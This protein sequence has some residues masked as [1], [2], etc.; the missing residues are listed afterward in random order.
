MYSVCACVHANIPSLT[1]LTSDASLAALQSRVCATIGVTR[2][3]GDH[4][5]RAQNTNVYVKPFLL[6]Q[7]EV[8]PQK[9]RRVIQI[10][11]QRPPLKHG[12]VLMSG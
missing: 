3:F 12:R 11:P 5:L 1:S 2:G 4:G 10:S 7:P 6:S 9:T 8:G